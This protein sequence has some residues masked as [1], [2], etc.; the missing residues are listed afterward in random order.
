MEKQS[1]LL[2]SQTNADQADNSNSTS[3]PLI[4]R[5]KIKGTPFWIIGDQDGWGIVLSNYRLTRIHQTKEAALKELEDEKWNLIMR[6]ASIIFEKQI[7]EFKNEHNI[8]TPTLYRNTQKP[9][10]INT[11]KQGKIH[12]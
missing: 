3:E 2:K 6:M 4:I 1:E 12:S 9:Q 5:E 7:E 11:P 10:Q 8:T